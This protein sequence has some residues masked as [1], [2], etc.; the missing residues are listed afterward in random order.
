M[1][2]RL[3]GELR[4]TDPE[5]WGTLISNSF[6]D[7]N[8]RPIGKSLPDTVLGHRFYTTLANPL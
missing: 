5:V 8:V 1:E 6:Q 4:A 2:P 7:M 3:N